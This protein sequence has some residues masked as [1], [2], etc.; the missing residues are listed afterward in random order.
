[1]QTERKEEQEEEQSPG[2]CLGVSLAAE[3]PSS[4]RPIPAP[5]PSPEPTSP[6]TIAQQDFVIYDF[7]D[8]PSTPLRPQPRSDLAA[9]AELEVMRRIWQETTE[10]ES[11]VAGGSST[12]SSMRRADGIARTIT[13]IEQEAALPDSISA[14]LVFAFGVPSRLVELLRRRCAS[15]QRLIDPSAVSYTHLTLPTKRIV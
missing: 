6:S 1:M 5:A 4:P 9:T 10:S 13:G 8:A 3:F 7:Y 11:S 12:D 2:P 14:E 15:A